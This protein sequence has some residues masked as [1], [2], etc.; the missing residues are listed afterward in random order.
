MAAS[1]SNIPDEKMNEVCLP[2][3]FLLFI[4]RVYYN[5]VSYPAVLGQVYRVRSFSVLTYTLKFSLS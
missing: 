3:L 5:T 2:S 4:S 1:D